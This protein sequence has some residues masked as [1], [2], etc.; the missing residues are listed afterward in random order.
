MP[1]VATF[2]LRELLH[3]VFGHDD[4]R[5]HQQDVCE[6]AAAGRD[7]LL[8]MPTGAGKSLCY[9]VP[10]LARGGT[11]LVISPLIALI[12]DQAQKL[13]GLGLR[14][15]RIHSGLPREDSRQACRDYLAGQLDFLFIAPE[16]MRVPGFP[17]MLAKRKPALVAI[18][19]AHC[20]S[21]WGH[22]FRPDYRTL[23]QHLQALR[24]APIIALTATATPAVQR[25]IVAQ[26]SLQDPA[27]FITG[28]RRTNLAVE[29]HELSKPQREEYTLKRLL[30]EEARPAIV[31]AASRKQAE[32][33]AGKLGGKF[34]TAAYHAGL[35]PDVRERVQRAF[36]TGK[37]D[38]VVATVAFGM[39]VDKADVRTVVHVALPGSV[40]AYYQ[41]IGRAGRD[42]RP[43]RTVLLYN[44]ADRKLQEFF[45]ERNY[46]PKDDLTRVASLLR[47][48]FREV[49]ELQRRAKLDRETLDRVIEKL[50]A[51]GVAVTDMSGAVRATGE[52]GWQTG[53]DAQVAFRREQIDR[54]MAFAEG[55]GCRMGALVRHFGERVDGNV[56][57]GICDLCKPTTEGNGA[58]RTPSIHEREDL[59]RILQTVANRSSSS[60]KL[61]TELNI[62]KDRSEFER[63]L[64]GL[65]RA[66]LVAIST[67]TFRNPE[68]RDISYK[69]VTVTHEGRTPDDA[70]LATV[71]LRGVEGGA[72]SG[73]KQKKQTSEAAVKLTP[74]QERLEEELRVWRKAEAA[75]LGKPAFFLFSDAVLRSIAAVAPKT[76]SALGAVSGVGQGKLDAYGAD[77]T[78]ICRGEKKNVVADKGREPAKGSRVVVAPLGERSPAPKTTAVPKPSADQA[79]RHRPV[80]LKQTH[81]ESALTTSQEELV[82]KLQDWRASQARTAGLPQ[83]LIFSDSVLRG[84]A[85]SEA[86]SLSELETV[87]G[88]GREKVERY[89]AAVLNVC[90]G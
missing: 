54:M 82:G 77:V 13:A 74:A 49:D 41:E 11:A 72:S 27:I 47:D 43:S 66:A 9:Q 80:I 39:G 70:T 63:M 40:E 55:T 87:S 31:Y 61:F 71:F 76:I 73:K 22:D 29:V 62:T 36:L 14:V 64:D 15:A 24:P 42:G 10:A 17:E 51:Q 45:L 34:P 37:L 23:G 4:F 59:R 89:G 85:Q 75:Q 20:I 26:L 67:D 16:R 12:E 1:G 32:E 44:F 60:G 5:P 21:Q 3:R 86:S 65:A 7:V 33:L 35:T 84:I 46:P 56:A 50:V 38:V 30:P 53:Y 6:S 68:G 57:C 52:R 19:E 81:A 79:P 8:V 90:R 2:D 58:M 28:F 18:D 88:F 78:A 83:F 25:D 48:E 69:K